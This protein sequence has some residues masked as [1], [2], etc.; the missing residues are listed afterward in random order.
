MPRAHTHTLA[1]SLSLSRARARSLARSQ[2][3]AFFVRR[4]S[5]E[6]APIFTA[7]SPLMA[8]QSPSAVDQIEV[9]CSP[10]ENVTTAFAP[11]CKVTVSNPRRT[12]EKPAG[13]R[14]RD[15][16]RERERRENTSGGSPASS[17][18]CKYS[19]GISAP[20]SLPVFVID[21]ETLRPLT[22]RSL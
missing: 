8:F 7:N 6:D 4:M 5:L 3:V 15:R 22:V 16:E 17:G 13:E 19:C 10:S 18:Y 9:S 21:T 11:G 14:A 20:G 2:N 12:W 1:R